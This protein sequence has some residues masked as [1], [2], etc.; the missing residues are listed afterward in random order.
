MS[1]GAVL[2]LRNGLLS[3]GDRLVEL[4][5]VRSR[6]G[7]VGALTTTWALLTSLI[8]RREIVKLAILKLRIKVGVTINC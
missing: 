1:F 4:V 8:W 6:T 5:S 7:M 3:F 2:G